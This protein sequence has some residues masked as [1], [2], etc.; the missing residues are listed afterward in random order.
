MSFDLIIKGGRILDGSGNPWFYGDIGVRGDT[1]TAI[2]RSLAGAEA[3]EVIN[4]AGRIVCPGFIDVHTHSDLIALAQPGLEPKVHQGVTTD[5]LGQDG[6]SVAP[7]RREH[8]VEWRKYIAALNGDHD[9]D[10]SWETFGE[11]LDALEAAR[12]AINLASLVPQGNARQ[13]VLGLENRAPSPAEAE[14]IDRLIAE[15]LEAGGFGLSIGLVYLPCLFASTEELIRQYRICARYGGLFVIHMRNEADYWLEAM[16]ETLMIAEQAGVSL[17]ISHFKAVGKQNWHKMPAA[18]EKLEQARQ[19]GIDVSF[20]Q[21]PYTAGSTVLSTILPPWANEGG[22]TRMLTRL[23]EESLRRQ[24]AREFQTGLPLSAGGWDNAVKCAGWDGIVVTSVRTPQNEWTVGCNFVQIAER[25]G[26][27]PEE[28]AFDLLLEEEGAVGMINF[29]ASEECI[30]MA[31]THD[32]Q[33]VGSDG[34]LVGKPH[35]RAYGTFP[36]I[37]GRY[38]REERVLTLQQAVRHMTSAP[39]QRLGLCD[40]G[41]LR[42]GLKAD[43]VIFDDAKVIDTGTYMEPRQFPLGIDDVLVNGVPVIRAGA[44]TGARPGRVLRRC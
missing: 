17:L 8:Q 41:L 39:A 22:T 9:I 44:N 10:W 19:R 28:A 21:Y 2:A 33:V 1:I 15:S 5:L 40:R 12:P 31:M 13:W 42:E 34:L 36:R 25:R 4:A 26:Q 6:I 23:R 35:P 18:L 37:L 20:D 7:I 32:L 16:D 43:I 11:Y 38:V 24:I 27:S 14:Q 3:P 29:I 30:R